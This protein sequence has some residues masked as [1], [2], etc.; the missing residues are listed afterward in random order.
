M[1]RAESSHFLSNGSGSPLI[2]ENLFLP[3]VMFDPEHQCQLLFGR[4]DAYVCND[5]NDEHSFCKE[6]WQG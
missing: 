5:Y 6:L 2:G 4:R 1:R 3:G